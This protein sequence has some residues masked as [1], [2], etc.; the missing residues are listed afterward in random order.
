MGATQSSNYVVQANFT[1][2]KKELDPNDEDLFVPKTC[3]AWLIGV[4]DYS[5]VRRAKKE[6]LP[7][8]K[9]LDQ[10][11]QDIANMTAF[12]ESLQF[13]RIIK[14][15]NPDQQQMDKSY[16]E[17]K[18]IMQRSHRDTTN[19]I[20]LYVYYGGHG[21]LENTTKIVLNE[22]DPM[23]R[24]F[25]LEQKLASLSKLNNNFIAA[26]FDCCREVIYRGDTRGVGESVDTQK[27]LTDQN[28]Y[29]TFGCPP[30]VG[31]P[32]KSTIVKSYTV[33]VTMHLNKT[34]GVLEIPAALD[35]KFKAK[36]EKAST[37]RRDVTK[38]LYYDVTRAG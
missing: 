5:E 37:E 10:V 30:L 35:F 23:F 17:I 2:Q 4:K 7:D 13:D 32:A 9:D 34:G 22:D 14:T 28:L 21:I 33:C 19:K 11:P 24:Y 36:F 38:Q 29:V 26:I 8:C 18:N 3:V 20:L 1:G 15:E 27:N 6:P 25:D 12:F 31:V 16:I